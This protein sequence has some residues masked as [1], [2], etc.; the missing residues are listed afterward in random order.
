MTCCISQIL[1]KIKGEFI[2]ITH[3]LVLIHHSRKAEQS[4][5]EQR[6]SHNDGQETERTVYYKEPVQ[7]LAL[8]NTPPATYLFQLVPT[9]CLPPPPRMPLYKSI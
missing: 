1:K 3:S 5:A 6:R 8:K 4:R 7:D 9:S 2:Y